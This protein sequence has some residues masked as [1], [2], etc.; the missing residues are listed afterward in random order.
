MTHFWKR[1][2]LINILRFKSILIHFKTIFFWKKGN[3]VLH[4]FLLSSTALK[5]CFKKRIS[6][7]VKQNNFP[8]GFH[9]YPLMIALEHPALRTKLPGV[10]RTI[11]YGINL[12][13]W[14]AVVFLH[15][16][17]HFGKVIWRGPCGGHPSGTV[18]FVFGVV[19]GKTS[20]VDR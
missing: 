5:N 1:F 17:Y 10:S 14:I 3:V 9:Y 4:P 7:Q 19:F 11:S 15:K 20:N 16:I 6:A 8:E 12:S 2:I 13:I 18:K